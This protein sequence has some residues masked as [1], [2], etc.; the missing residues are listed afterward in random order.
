LYAYHYHEKRVGRVQG[1]KKK[2]KKLF[3]VSKTATFKALFLLEGLARVKSAAGH[4]E[5]GGGRKPFIRVMFLLII[6]LELGQ[7]WEKYVCYLFGVRGLQ[8]QAIG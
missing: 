8:Q 2:E 6:T 5:M 4:S 3:K 7:L 1:G